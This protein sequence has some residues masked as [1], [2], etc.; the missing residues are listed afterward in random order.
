[1]GVGGRALLS[2]VTCVAAFCSLVYELLLGQS[3]SAFLGNTIL[4]YSITIGLYLF[5]MGVGA[6]YVEARLRSNPLQTLINVELLL[7][8]LGGA[9]LLLLFG[10]DQ[11]F[12]SGFGFSLGVYLLILGVGLL[13]GMELPLLMRLWE[14]KNNSSRGVGAV[15]GLSY[16]GALIGTLTFGFWFY[17]IIGLPKTAFIAG[18]INALVAMALLIAAHQQRR[19]SHALVRG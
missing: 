6:I 4:R 1:M 11:V 17:P 3:L 2:V 18:G 8:V 16:C 13:T 7:S 10:L 9:S 5:S 14:E 15:L 19:V 12:L